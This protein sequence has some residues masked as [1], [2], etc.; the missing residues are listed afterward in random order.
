MAPSNPGLTRTSGITFLVEPPT[1]PASTAPVGGIFKNFVTDYGGVPDYQTQLAGLSITASSNLLTSTTSLWAAT[2]VGKSIYVEDAGTGGFATANTLNTTISSFISPTQ[3]R[4]TGNAATTLTSSTTRRVSWGTDN[5][6]QIS[7]F[8]S[9]QV[10][11]STSV[12]LTV[13]AG[14]YGFFVSSGG[15]G[16][17]SNDADFWS[18]G[19]TDLHVLMTGATFADGEMPGGDFSPP[20]QL[21]GRGVINDVNNSARLN[22]VSSGATTVTLTNSSNADLFTNGA[23]VMISGIDLQ[24]SGYPPNWYL[25]EYRQITGISTATGVITLNAAL[26]NGYLSTWPLYG[27]FAGSGGP[28]GIFNMGTTFPPPVGNNSAWAGTTTFVGGTFNSTLGW[29]TTRQNNT[30][31]NCVFGTGLPITNSFNATVN[32]GGSTNAAPEIDKVTTNLTWSNHNVRKFIIQSASILNMTM[33]NLTISS[34]ESGPA[35]TGTVKNHTMTN[36]ITPSL[37]IGP[38]YGYTQSVVCSNCTI[39]AITAAGPLGGGGSGNPGVQDHWTFSSGVFTIPSSDAAFV[40]SWAVPGAAA[41]WRGS[42]AFQNEMMFRITDVSMSAGS[43]VYFVTTNWTKTSSLPAVP[44]SSHLFVQLAPTEAITFTNCSGA[45]PYTTDFS[46]AP[47]AG[48]IYAYSGRTYNQAHT[49]S[50]QQPVTLWGALQQIIIDVTTPYTG[51]RPTLTAQVMDIQTLRTSDFTQIRYSP[52]VDLKVAG[53]RVITPGSVTGS[54]GSDSGLTL[55]TSVWFMD[56]AFTGFN[57]SANVSTEAGGNFSVTVR[58]C[59]TQGI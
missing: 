1:V 29:G 13:P 17:P 26:D 24:A 51:V 12:Y 7:N 27:S 10:A 21:G 14:A 37:A 15:T 42:G 56:Q 49:S 28:A 19:F 2:D 53:Q 11:A 44:N 48:H 30:F 50:I 25:F 58:T 55:A 6:T 46:C 35:I 45:D 57:P 16:A 39:D 43:S 32:G 36:V 4:L 54:S 47:A 59:L 40:C 20:F 33:S 5:Y 41:M 22:T 9:S 34:T 38:P 31:T 8:H 18:G 3:I 23:W 52:V